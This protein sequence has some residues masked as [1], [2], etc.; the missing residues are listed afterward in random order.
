MIAVLSLA[1]IASAS[2]SDAQ[3]RWS[4]PGAIVVNVVNRDL[5]PLPGVTVTIERSGGQEAEPASR[6]VTNAG[7]HAEFRGLPAGS[8]IVRVS[9]PGHLDMAFGPVPIEEANPPSV[10]LPEI[11]AVVNPIMKFAGGSR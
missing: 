5:S 10:R 4:A 8:Y 3:I 7:G 9:A 11:L 2:G 6:G 1:L